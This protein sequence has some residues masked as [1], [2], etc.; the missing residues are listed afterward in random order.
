MVENNGC[1]RGGGGNQDPIDP[2]PPP[3]CIRPRIRTIYC[4]R[5]WFPFYH[6]CNYQNLALGN[7]LKCTWFFFFGGIFFCY[8]RIWKITL[9]NSLILCL[10][11]L[12]K[13]FKVYTIATAVRSIIMHTLI[14]QKVRILLDYWASTDF[15]INHHFLVHSGRNVWRRALFS[16]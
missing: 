9:I 1:G 11:K 14:I 12:K 6:T 13:H 4:Y 2:Y 16:F 10:K 8:V 3:L 5:V 7:N 15:L